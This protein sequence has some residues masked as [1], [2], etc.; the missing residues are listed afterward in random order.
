MLAGNYFVRPAFRP[1]REWRLRAACRYG[2]D[3][4]SS[5]TMGRGP[6]MY[7][8]E[9]PR[10]V[11]RRRPADCS[12]SFAPLDHLPGPV[13]WPRFRSPGPPVAQVPLAGWVGAFFAGDRGV[14]PVATA[15][16]LLAGGSEFS[17]RR[18]LGVAPLPTPPS[19]SSPGG[20]GGRPRS[21][22]QNFPLRRV[23]RG[24]LVPKARGR[25][26]PVAPGFPPLPT[27]LGVLVP[28]PEVIP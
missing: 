27:A 21:A 6:S 2:R 20:S 22:T 18:R 17:L 16:S 3:F 15:Q 23:A 19:S 4:G 13:A 11:S 12:A 24:V 28:K 25:P 14:A 9:G 8:M 1:P 10:L 5:G 26:L 7:E